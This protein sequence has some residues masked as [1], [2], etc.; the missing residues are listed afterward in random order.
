MTQPIRHY[1]TTST[2]H[3]ADQRERPT[4]S[5]SPEVDNQGG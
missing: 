1:A 2:P 3:C 5:P 4:V